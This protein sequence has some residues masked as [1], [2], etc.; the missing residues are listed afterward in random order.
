MS[1]RPLVLCLALAAASSASADEPRHRVA[2]YFAGDVTL[3]P[4]LGGFGIALVRYDHVQPR[5]QL[6]LV[7]EFNSDTLRLAIDSLPVGKSMWVGVELKGEA[8]VAGLAPT[9]YQN[10]TI[11]PRRGYFQSYLAGRGYVKAGVGRS[12]LE[13]ALTVRGWFANRI[14]GRTA[15]TLILPPRDAVGE[16]RA[17][18]TWWGLAH[19]PSLAEPHRFSRRARGVAFGFELGVNV[20]PEAHAWGAREFMQFDPRDLGNTPRRLQWLGRQWL[21]AGAQLGARV[22]VQLE[23]SAMYSVGLDDRYRARL[24]GQNPYSEAIPG[25]PW[26]AYV[27]GRYLAARASVH[28][29]IW[30]DLEVGAMIATAVVEDGERTGVRPAPRGLVGLQAFL[31]ARFG[32]YVVDARVG[33]SPFVRPGDA[34]GG[35]GVFVGFGTLWS[36]R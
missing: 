32:N 13:L 15:S 7:A 21:L 8:L 1:I 4:G 28:A 16:L 35:I 36:R 5:S 17:Y 19:D 31:D 3:A 23:E 26:A 29:A 27:S 9:Y 18:Y 10:G 20:E 24:G 30:R 6:R 12:Y 34:R 25:Q 14:P 11:D 22:R 2:M 33:W